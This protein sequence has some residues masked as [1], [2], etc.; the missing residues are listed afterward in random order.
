MEVTCT[1][2]FEMESEEKAR[3][4]AD[5]VKVD[6]ENFV[7][8]EVSGSRILATITAKDVSSLTH[9]IDDYMACISIAEKSL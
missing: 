4:V 6:D 3:A 8:T 9:T 5:S 1:L 7:K 2:E